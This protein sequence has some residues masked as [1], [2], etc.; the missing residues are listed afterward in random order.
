MCGPE[1]EHGDGF[2]VFPGVLA[3]ADGTFAAHWTPHV[4]LTGGDGYVRPECVWAALDCPTSAP[5]ANFGEGPPMVLA[6]L[7]A[8]LVA[9]GP[10]SR[11]RSYRGR[12]ARDGRKRQAA[13]A[14][15][16]EAGRLLC[17]AAALWIE[18]RE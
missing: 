18:L 4:A 1:R 15:F 7:T 17:A 8:R 10:A 16:D 6:R 9:S 11:T 2:G 3:E 14:L 12:R 13:C 5:V